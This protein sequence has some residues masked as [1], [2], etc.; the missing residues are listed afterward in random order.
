MTYHC[1]F[2]LVRAQDVLDGALEGGKKEKNWL[3]VGFKRVWWKT[4]LKV[5]MT[6]ADKQKRPFD[7]CGE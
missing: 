3:A 1:A 6:L 4:L 2:P 7:S 5:G